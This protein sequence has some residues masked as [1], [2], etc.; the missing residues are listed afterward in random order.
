M[1]DD[2][3]MFKHILVPLDGSRLSARA[4]PYAIELAG[5]FNSEITLLRVV[6]QTT[7]FI[8]AETSGMGSAIG[9]E[10]TIDAA[11][12]QDKRNKAN[13]E[14]YL[15]KQV[16]KLTDKGIKASSTVLLGSPAESIIKHC[17]KNR[18]SLVVMTTHGRSGFK[19][20]IL[21]SVADKIV[22]EPGLV[23]MVIHPRS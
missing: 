14:R 18:I 17:R 12:Y 13:A 20:A 8:I 1:E 23:A 3:K 11:R 7:P 21:G 5:K 19:R 10:M 2:F 16:K 9:A 6:K 15:Q 22:H 4:L